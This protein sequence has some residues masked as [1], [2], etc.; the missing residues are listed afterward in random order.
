MTRGKKKRM[1]QK[2]PSLFIMLLEESLSK[3]L[4]GGG[5][6][7]RGG[8]IQNGFA[9]NKSLLSHTVSRAC[10]GYENA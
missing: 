4:A 7:I 6:E 8:N 5:G 9:A 10:A 2:V 1:K 3:I